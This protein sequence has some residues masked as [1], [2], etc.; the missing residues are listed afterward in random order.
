MI[1]ARE[2]ASDSWDAG[3]IE[4]PVTCPRA[5]FL[6]NITGLY[7]SLWSLSATRNDWALENGWCVFNLANDL[8]CKRALLM[9]YSRVTFIVNLRAMHFLW[10]SMTAIFHRHTRSINFLRF[11]AI[12]ISIYTERACA[13]KWGI[14][15][16]DVRK[17]NKFLHA[18]A[19]KKLGIV[20]CVQFHFSNENTGVDFF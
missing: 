1:C 2:R 12:W 4:F 14:F 19:Q 5:D 6:W 10:N 11:A 16:L 9:R 15:F 18:C 8:F 3:E 17:S 7:L 13:Y 20:V